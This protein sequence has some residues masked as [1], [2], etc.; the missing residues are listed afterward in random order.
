MHRKRCPDGNE[1][2]ILLIIIIMFSSTKPIR[3]QQIHPFLNILILF[4]FF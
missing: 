2:F 3:F 4:L 1:N